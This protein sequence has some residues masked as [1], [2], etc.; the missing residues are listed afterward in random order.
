MIGKSI[1]FGYR[2]EEGGS[3]SARDSA[4]HACMT[5]ATLVNSELCDGMHEGMENECSLL[6]E[7]LGV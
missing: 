1:Q 6:F 4:L 2:G 7:D 5:N 3:M